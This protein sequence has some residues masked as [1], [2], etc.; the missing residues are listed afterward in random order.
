MK[1]SVR[2]SKG[3]LIAVAPVMELRPHASQDVRAL[4][5][6]R[7]L[8]RL[9]AVV[10]LPFNVRA[11]T[12]S[13]QQRCR[14]SVA[15]CGTSIEGLELRELL[16]SISPDLAQSDVVN[17]VALDQSIDDQIHALQQEL[18]QQPNQA[19]VWLSLANLFIERGNAGLDD[20]SSAIYAEQQ[21]LQIDP[22][23][24][25][26]W[27]SAAHLLLQ[28]GDPNLDDLSNAIYSEQRSLQI[29]PNQADVW[30]S[31]A[32]LLLERGDAAQDDLSNAIYSEQQSLQV[33]PNQAD[34]W[35]SLANLFLQRGNSATNDLSN[36][37][38]AE[39]RS[40]G[41]LP[42]Q[43][44]VWLSLSK[45]LLQR[46]SVEL[47]DLSNAIYAEQQSLQ[48]NPNQA[49]VWF[50]LANLFVERGG[51]ASGDLS[52]AIYADQRSLGIDPNQP[53]V[54]LSLA[55]LYVQQ[56]SSTPSDLESAIAAY[57]NELSID[58]D[59]GSIWLALGYAYFKNGDPVD[60]RYALDRAI[61][62]HVYVDPTLL[63][64]ATVSDLV[65]Y[66]ADSAL[67]NGAIAAPAVKNDQNYYQVEWYFANTMLLGFLSAPDVAG[68]DRFAI[69]RK[70]LSVQLDSM[71]S[72]G[73]VPYRYFRAD[74]TEVFQTPDGTLLNTKPDADDSSGSMLA[75]ALWA[76][77]A[78]TGDTSLFMQP[79]V[80]GK[81][82]QIGQ[83]LTN[84]QDPTTGLTRGAL[85]SPQ[86]AVDL[87][88]NSETYQGFQSLALINSVIYG[89]D[90]AASNNAAAADHVR[91][92]ILT[93]LYTSSDPQHPVFYWT[94]PGTDADSMRLAVA[95][96]SDWYPR[97][98]AQVWPVLYHV[99]PADSEIAQFELSKI[100]A[101]WN[102]VTQQNWVTRTD[103]ASV[104]YAALLT[105]DLIRP[106]TAFQ[107]D[108]QEPFPTPQQSP[109][110]VGVTTSIADW[111]LDLQIQAPVANDVSIQA[112]AG[113]STSVNVRAS[114]FD[115]HTS[116]A[117]ADLEVSPSWSPRH[118]TVK[119]QPD[120][121]LLYT[122]DSGFTGD[123]RF[124][125]R[126]RDS[127]GA[128]SSAIV[129]V[130][131]SA[132]LAFDRSTLADAQAGLIYNQ[133]ILA[134]GGVGSITLGY[135]AT[136]V[137]SFTDLGLEVTING[138]AI[139]FTGTPSRT[140]T[141]L[142]NVT[143]TDTR[144]DSITTGFSI[145]VTPGAFDA[146]KSLLTLTSSSLVS[147]KT[148]T[149][150]L[151]AKDSF[152]NLL[153]GGGL[154]VTFG[155]GVGTAQGTFATVVDH[156]DG[157]YTSVFTGIKVGSNTIE[158]LLNGMVVSLSAS[159]SVSPGALSLSRSTI[160]ASNSTIPLHGATTITLIAKD[161][162]GNQ[163]T[164]GGLSVKFA[165]QGVQKKRANLG[166]VQDNHNGTYQVSL[167]GSVADSFTITA[168]I[169]G[170]P[171][172]SGS[173]TIIVQ[174]RRPK[175]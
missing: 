88:D 26:V 140:G 53:P 134:N 31:V 129:N 10:R 32:D 97:S 123:D 132:P 144:G 167:T 14:R 142:F 105:G 83:L 91:S 138:P 78:A 173:L 16:T 145:T 170:L 128:V 166:K 86:S 11:G 79:G 154:A 80:R 106:T 131:V 43:A 147:G 8:N 9:F 139:S 108:T 67:P 94:L 62:L 28:R 109:N 7:L 122:A 57:N 19:D 71:S 174:P 69:A 63:P 169:G 48:I 112:V 148:A 39:Q 38:Y 59:N 1:K 165:S 130:T 52:N 25:A 143:A 65:R 35:L 21:S 116:A 149:I 68:I 92:G 22:N 55:N 121:T 49:D 73:T 118:G 18:A 82:D 159:I 101:A 44:G 81:I 119:L 66:I 135:Q 3:I 103:S 146:Q 98:T 61:Q 157:T 24:A 137:T 58:Q 155:T 5:F 136:S 56:N 27:L 54:I 36:A 117:D 6:R 46:G 151:T 41:I 93:Y 29:D 51:S 100:D 150:T 133:T 20:L 158:T 87:Q 64:N 17:V 12:S 37:I 40:L 124:G 23:Q 95:D 89:D 111:G 156:H 125:Y 85:D 168:T 141:V 160:Q 114:D 33:N 115:L 164:S 90:A 77:Y 171:V 104:G 99:V 161:Q 74:G 2:Q 13:R 175:H 42:N 76:Y 107:T 15:L 113:V 152:G 102:G 126:I 34:V 60:G 70:Y 162:N 110:A 50:S 120:G 30:L 72:D 45:L 163:L 127:S 4:M 153:T 172:T 96:L 75:T 84:L 47:D